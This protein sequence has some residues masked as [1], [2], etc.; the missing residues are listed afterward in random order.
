MGKEIEQHT[1]NISDRRNACGMPLSSDAQMDTFSPLALEDLRTFG[2]TQVPLGS[3]LGE[4]L[5]VTS[6]HVVCFVRK[7]QLN[8]AETYRQ[9]IGRTPNNFTIIESAE[10]IVAAAAITTQQVAPIVITSAIDPQEKDIMFLNPSF[11]EILADRFPLPNPQN[12]SL[13]TILQCV[14]ITQHGIEVLTQENDTKAQV[15]KG[16]NLEQKRSDRIKRVLGDIITPVDFRN[17]LRSKQVKKINIHVLG[18]AGTNISQAAQLYAERQGISDKTNIIVY[19]SGIV[20]LVYAQIAAEETQ[21]SFAT[22]SLPE[23][24]HLHVECAVYDSMW[25]LY[26]GRMEESVFIDEQDMALDSMQLAAQLSID[27]LRSIVQKE[28]KIRLATHPS[29]QPLVLPWI[30]KGIAQW[31]EASSN[32]A[33]ALMVTRGEAD[34]CITTASTIALLADKKIQTLH[35]FGSPNMIFTIASPLNQRLLRRYLD[36]GVG[37]I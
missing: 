9:I 8:A 28:G 31:T 12:S 10:L 33:A 11:G 29:P 21:E 35:E 5:E 34:A 17:I 16:Q 19:G 3:K 4:Q 24:L 26:Q 22:G 2:K 13:S 30:T 15:V 32:S 14:G 6:A 23:T 36:E 27:E 25:K 18:P 1:E 7:E 37:N 20:P